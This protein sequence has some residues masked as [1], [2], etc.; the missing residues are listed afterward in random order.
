MNQKV[1]DNYN[2]LKHQRIKVPTFYVWNENDWNEKKIECG[3]VFPRIEFIN[4]TGHEY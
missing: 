2:L 1:I 4:C 3:K